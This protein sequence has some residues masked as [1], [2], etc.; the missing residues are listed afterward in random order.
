[1]QVSVIIPCYLL[2]DAD[3]G[4]ELLE[5]A[6]D[7]LQSLRKFTQ[8]EYELI[9]IDN[10][11]PIGANW[12]IEQADVYIRNKENLGYG[13]AVNQGLKIARGD[14]LVVSNNDIVFIHDW[15]SNAIEQWQE[16]DGIVS[17]HLI[18]NDPQ[19]KTNRYLAPW[20]HF[21]GALW[22]I[23][24]GI[25]DEIGLLDEQFEIGMYE[26]RDYVRRVITHG[27]RHVK[28]GWCRHIGNAT[29]GKIPG[30]EQIFFRNK[31]RFEKKWQQS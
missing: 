10:G 21:F 15:I 20:G 19:M 29:W 3:G 11:S 16:G 23:K 14:W 27:L 6:N 24:R 7:C 30:Q 31:E 13:P 12:L 22:M 26:D 1:M 17:S 18:D 25:V 9:L 28:A 8:I 5:F 2:P 4:S